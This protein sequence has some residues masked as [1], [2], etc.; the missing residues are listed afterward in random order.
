MNNSRPSGAAGG[1]RPE[2]LVLGTAPE[3]IV[4]PAASGAGGAG[5]RPAGAG[6]DE[7]RE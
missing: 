7:G 2:G 1:A 4:R 3:S 5:L 6:A